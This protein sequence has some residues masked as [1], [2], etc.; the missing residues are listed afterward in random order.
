MKTVNNDNVSGLADGFIYNS[1]Y[2]ILIC[3]DCGSMVQPE[4][5]SF[6]SHLNSIHRITGTACKALMDRFSAYELCALSELDVP[7]EKVT[8][9]AGLPIHRGFRCNIC[10]QSPGSSYFTISSN[11]IRDH[12]SK[13]KLGMVP[14][15]AEQQEKFQPCYIQT[16]SS[17]KERIRYFEVEPV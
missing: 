16:F 4:T 14:M 13:H 8:R 9:I 17:A 7:K 12:I 15:R 11:K 5:K 6:Y 2:Q 10:P 1:Q 3:A